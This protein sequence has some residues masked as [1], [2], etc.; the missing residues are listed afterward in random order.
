MRNVIG[1]IWREAWLTLSAYM[2]E[3]LWVKWTKKLTKKSK[4]M[5]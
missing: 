4:R 2:S 3:G 1:F 5:G